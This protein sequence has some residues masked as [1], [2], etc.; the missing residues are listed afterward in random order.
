MRFVTSTAHEYL[1]LG[2]RGQLRN[3]GCAARAMLLPGTTCVRVAGTKQE[4]CFAMT[5]ES[6]DGIPLRFKGLVVYRVVDPVAAAT[7][8]D[9]T[10]GIGHERIQEMIAHVCLG[11]LRDV[12]SHASLETCM[13]GRRTTLTSAVAEGLRGVIGGAGDG[14]FGPWGIELDVVQVSQVYIVDDDLRQ[15]LET[16]LRNQVVARAERSNLEMREDLE[17]AQLASRRRLDEEAIETERASNEVE[18]ER[19][20]LS[21][22]LDAERIESE[23]EA[24]RLRASAD[25]RAEEEEEAGRRASSRRLETQALEDD[26]ERHRAECE[27]LELARQKETASL[28]AEHASNRLALE[29]RGDRLPLALEVERQ[30]LAIRDLRVQAE[31]LPERGRAEIERD[32]MPERQV[33][34]VAAALA[35]MFQGADLTVYGTENGVLESVRPLVDL[36]ARRL[37]GVTAMRECES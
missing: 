1:V 16:E 19:I 15:R 35:S 21:M 30:A 29:L 4:A 13:E 33:P 18:C 37:S 12:V 8:F 6:K 7:A 36:I 14:S 27:R 20:R 23:A 9:F 32:L 10:G 24:Q 31:L 25:I 26:R 5:Q 2:R 22:A 3:L 17:R 11:E 28:E 34:E